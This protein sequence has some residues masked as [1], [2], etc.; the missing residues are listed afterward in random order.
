MVTAH[1]VPNDWALKPSDLS[2]GDTFR[3]LFVTTGARFAAPPRALRTYNSFV[4]GEAGHSS[5][6]AELRALSEHF[7]ALLSTGAVAA[8]DNTATTGTGVP[9]YWLDGAKVAD[10]YGGPLRR[11]L[12]LQRAQESCRADV[13]RRGDR[14]DRQ[15]RRRHGGIR[16]ARST[17]ALGACDR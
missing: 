14:V 9:I 7:T 17:S 16:S 13:Q 12:G 2:A 3:L 8:R 15:Q 4:R 6:D 1:T 10:D 5:V 11:H